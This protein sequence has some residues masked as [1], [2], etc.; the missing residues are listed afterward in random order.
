M[1][2]KANLLAWVRAPV[3][4]ADFERIY[5][6]QLPKI[7]NFFRYRV[8]DGPLAED[9]TALTF[10]KAWRHRDRYQDD[11][12]SFSTWLFTIARR[13][14]IDHYRKR[15]P[16]VPYSQA[17]PLATD[18]SPE[19]ITEK[20]DDFQ[21]LALLLEQLD[22]RQRELVALRYGAGLTNRSIAELTGLSQSNV[23]VILHRTLKQLR[24]Q[25]EVSP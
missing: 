17:G 5:R 2:V 15:K 13:V 25:W 23:G 12:A 3:S 1:G 7:Y 14:A 22:D 19:R 10:E 24:S 6:L 16:E 21:R 18:K 4:E 8:G 20:Q 9:L 11:L